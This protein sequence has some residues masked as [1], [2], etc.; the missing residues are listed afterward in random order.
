MPK[1]GAL[2]RAAL[3]VGLVVAAL[4]FSAAPQA[5]AVTSR[6]P[7]NDTRPVGSAP[8]RVDFPIEYFGLVADLPSRS[9]HLSEHG[10]A[11]YGEARFRVRGRWTPWQALGQDGA[12]APGQFTG[13]LVSVARAD[14]YQVRA[15]PPGASSWRAAA[16]NTTDGPS[17]VVG[18]RRADA[19]TAAPGCMSR[20]DW[21]ADESISGWAD[22][23]VQSYSPVQVLTVH[24]TAGSNDPSQDY[25][26]T[27]RAIYSY[28]VQTNEW[29]DIGYQYLVDGHGIVYEGRNAGHT[30][31]SCRYD[32]G[33]GTDFAHQAGTDQV[34]TGAH[35]KDNNVGNVGIALLGCYEPTSSTCSGDTSPTPA[36]IDALDREVA[37][38]S[39]RHD[40]DPDGAVHYVNP[41]SGAAKDV[42][43][44]TGHRDWK[45]TECPG[46]TLYAQLPE[47][48]TSTVS[49]QRGGQTVRED[50]GTVR[51]AVVRTG[52]THLAASVDY[53][54]ASGTATSGTD[55]TVTPGTL[56]FAAGETTKTIPLTITDDSA[57]EARETVVVSLSS[58]G[59]ATVLG[60]RASIKVSIAPSDQRPDG[61][62]STA[63]ASGYVGNDVYNATGYGQTR[64]VKARR[65]QARTFFVRVYNDGSVDNTFALR[66]S[67]ARSGSWVSYYSGTT[68]ITTAMR[69]STGWKMRLRPGAY[70]LVEVRIGIRR[71]ADFGSLKPARVSASWT[72]DGTRTDLVKA[73]VKVVR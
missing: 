26:A 43:T 7:L 16:I 42:P 20:A 60:S 31:V 24:H 51:L 72:C 6:K 35:T 38:L 47:I 30:S 8:V 69:T 28:H 73:V 9:A 54:R 32:G 15:L 57:R 53:A 3:V 45:N 29:A 23:D 34:V 21:G 4:S 63:S 12:Q 58:P 18:H 11:P 1:P 5:E 27:V 61:W 64:T 19:A 52:N 46:A 56:S 67:A 39:A 50:G 71:T 14:A 68:N 59:D 70:R 41:V 10:R 40:L 62:V 37:S 65:A 13:S 55:F 36:A 17:V 2:A 22:A 33:D 66:G 44:I 49:F 25:A 48:R